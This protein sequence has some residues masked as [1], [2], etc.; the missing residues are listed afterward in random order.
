MH[1][2]QSQYIERKFSNAF[3]GKCEKGANQTKA[4]RCD[5]RTSDH[6]SYLGE[7]HPWADFLHHRAR[8]IDWLY[9]GEVD[10]G[11][12]GNDAVIAQTLSMTSTQVFLIRTR[13]RSI[14]A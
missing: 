12:K 13:D 11:C 9:S 10:N 1:R 3:S 6:Q 5:V 4:R 8:A 14:P 2:S 7:G